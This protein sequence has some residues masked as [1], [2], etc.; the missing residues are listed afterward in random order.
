MKSIVLCV[1][2]NQKCLDTL[3]ALPRTLEMQNTKVHLVHAFEIHFY[4]ID[5]LP[6]IYPTE[7]QYPDIEKSTL[8]IL[9]QLGADMGLDPNNLV[10]ECFFTHSR[11]QK[12]K[13]Y[14]I[15]VKAGL[16]VVA[17]RGQHGIEGLFSSSLA[18]FL[19][20]YS[21]CHVMVMRPNADEISE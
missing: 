3:K 16:T 12:I 8:A 1:D 15:E 7:E 13:E 17:T 18:D 21:P 20:K 19:V 6:V 10:T 14:L 2:L 9:N 11:E 4:N 5:L